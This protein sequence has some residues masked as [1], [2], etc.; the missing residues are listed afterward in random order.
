MKEAKSPKITDTICC[1]FCKKGRHEVAH[2]IEGPV[3]DDKYIYI[4]NECVEL[5]YASLHESSEEPEAPDESLPVAMTPL[6]IKLHL[7]EYI[8]GQDSAKVAISVA[9]YNHYKRLNMSDHAVEIDKSN[10]LMIGPSGAGK[11]LTVKTVARLFSIPYIIADATS[12][13]E[14]GY[15]GEDVENLICRLITDADGDVERAQKGIIFIDEID[16]KS[17]RSESATVSRDVSG[18]GVQQALLK[19]MEGTVMEVEYFDDLVEFDTRDVLFIFSGA[20]MGLDETIKNNSGTAAIG[21]GAAMKGNISSTELIKSA[22]THDLI[23]YGMIPEFVGRCPVVVVF[24]DLTVDTMVR[25]LKEP[26]NNI[27]SQFR[28]LF[29]Y[30]GVELVFQDHYLISVADRCMKQKTGARGLRS[31]MEADLRQVQY[32]LPTVAAGG[33]VKIIIGAD[34][35][36]EYVTAG[37]QP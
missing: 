14:A 12:I 29:E 24:D 10:L 32:T 13:T 16:K 30:D 26:R 22:T 8:I 2:F 21:F 35:Y 20:F 11:T 9:I 3:V 5:S 34:G 17:R 31:I 6:D 19:M 15:V 25:I 28:A 36:V 18:E 27:T 37:E 4:C 1:T 7:D 33:A 23:K